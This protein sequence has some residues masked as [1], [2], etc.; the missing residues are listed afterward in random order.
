MFFNINW[1]FIKMLGGMLESQYKDLRQRAIQELREK[2]RFHRE[3]DF[4]L[5]VGAPGE[6][7]LRDREEFYHRLE[8]VLS[9]FGNGKLF[10]PH[11]DLRRSLR[12]NQ[13]VEITLGI[14]V[15]SSKIVL[16]HSKSRSDLSAAMVQ[17]AY[18]ENVPVLFFRKRRK[19]GKPA[20]DEQA[21]SQHYI[22]LL[23]GR[24]DVVE[25]DPGNRK[26]LFERIEWY[27]KRLY[28]VEER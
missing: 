15:P 20:D 13:V 6:D 27:V 2:N 8:G 22:P 1:V 28:P 18:F 26:E 24:H 21:D 7:A 25:F 3:Y 23:R 12:D 14:V 9:K 4:C 5:A 10:V 17:K 16:C 19:E 11:R